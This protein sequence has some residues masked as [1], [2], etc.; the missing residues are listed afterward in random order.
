MKTVK[1]VNGFLIRNTLDLD[2]SL[3]H[4][5]GKGI[6]AIHNKYY[7]PKDEIWIDAPFRKE[8]QFLLKLEGFYKSS[9]INKELT[10]NESLKGPFDQKRAVLKKL[11]LPPPIP[12]YVIKKEQNKS[13]K[14]VYVDGSIVRRYLDPDFSFGGHEF[15]YS[16]IAKGE[17]WIDFLMDKKEIPYAVL[18]ETTERSL[19]QKG[20]KDYNIA[21]D[22]ANVTEKE[23]RI[24]DG[25][26][27]YNMHY[28]V[29][30]WKNLNDSEIRSKYYV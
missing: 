27:S 3:L 21:H 16:Y 1:Y 9:E 14:L 18:H 11:C 26:G 7:I 19:M 10:E 5:Y 17:I 23:A 2:F 22:Y 28:D 24:R 4:E 15:V 20:G 29:F 8:T 13:I 6:A 30:K 12:N 25:Y